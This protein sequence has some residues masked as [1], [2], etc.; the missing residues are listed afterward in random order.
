MPNQFACVI[1]PPLID[2]LHGVDCI[3]QS[4]LA[5]AEYKCASIFKLQ[6][7]FQ[8]VTFSFYIGGVSL[9]IEDLVDNLFISF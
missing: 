7:G 2:K 4:S 1:T 8:H 6:A 5:E 3:C 9:E